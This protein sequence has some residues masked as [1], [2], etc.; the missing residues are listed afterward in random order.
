MS[1]PRE[2]LIRDFA[3]A[4]IRIRGAH[5]P[6]PGEPC[7]WCQLAA[8]QAAEAVMTCNIALPAPRVE[9]LEAALDELSKEAAGRR[10]ENKDSQMMA[11]GIDWA[12]RFVRAALGSPQERSG[13]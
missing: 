5:N 1:E 9:R 2:R 6:K 11:L 12:V 13:E 10:A 7:A 3:S 8:E 4:F